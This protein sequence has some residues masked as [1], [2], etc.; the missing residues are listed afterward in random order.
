[1]LVTLCCGD[2]N[3]LPMRSRGRIGDLAVGGEI[4]LERAARGEVA[5]EKHCGQMGA[6]NADG[7]RIC[8]E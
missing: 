5:V 3:Q 7:M 8:V 1:M 2:V 6:G 4:A